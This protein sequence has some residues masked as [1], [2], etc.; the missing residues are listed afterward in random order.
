MTE[1]EYILPDETRKQIGKSI[2]KLQKYNNKSEYLLKI[3]LLGTNFKLRDRLLCSLTGETSDYRT[4]GTY[5]TGADFYTLKI[6]VKN[7]Q[8]KLILVSAQDYLIISPN[9]IG[10]YYRGAS[11]G[12]IVFD[13]SD[14]ESFEKVT[15]LLEEF[16]KN[17]P[18]PDIPVALLGINTN[19]EE[20]STDEGKATADLLNLPYYETST[21]KFEKVID[22]FV[23]LSEQVIK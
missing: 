18:S 16:R 9:Y 8:T 7:I 15:D 21:P 1:N 12:L 5:L 4:R 22:I 10:N 17:I 13:K 23:Y 3:P 20:V 2:G 19:E 6:T 11:A 14:R